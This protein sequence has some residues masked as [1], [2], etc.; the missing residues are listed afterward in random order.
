MQ[1]G[2]KKFKVCRGSASFTQSNKRKSIEQEQKKLKDVVPEG[3]ESIVPFKGPV[4]DIINQL[5]G[6][7]KS[8]MSYTNSR[9]IAEL[10]KNV[11]FVRISNAG[12]RESGPHDI[13]VV[14]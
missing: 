13:H 7:V 10:Q 5:V 11:E 8:G 4:E 9:T 2:D 1:K 3:V 12:L 14:T 6:G